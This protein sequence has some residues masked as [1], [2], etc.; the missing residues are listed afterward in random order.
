MSNEQQQNQKVNPAKVNEKFTEIT[1][2]LN[3]LFGEESFKGSV[4][5][6]GDTAKSIVAEILQERREELEK[7]VKNEFKA[8]VAKRVDHER[9]IKKYREEFEK[10][11]ALKQQEYINAANSILSKIDAFEEDTRDFG[12][13]IDDV[14]GVNGSI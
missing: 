13:S 8:L 9:E 2:K 11:V 6:S 10:S 12:K 5:L 14:T 3:R 1:T 7:T 4:K